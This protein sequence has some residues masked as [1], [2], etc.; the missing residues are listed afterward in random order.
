VQRAPA[1]NSRQTT[2][3]LHGTER[4]ESASLEAR[5]DSL[6]YVSI[7]GLTT[8]VVL[9]PDH[10]IPAACALNFDHVAMAQRN[11]RRC[12]SPVRSA[13]GKVRLALPVGCGFFLP[14]IP[15]AV[16]RAT[17]PSP[18]NTGYSELSPRLRA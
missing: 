5:R 2:S 12:V 6:V 10:V 1:M 13:L 4:A 7:R 11:W 15:T 18:K 16:T 17:T 3:R 14:G 9:T 8:E